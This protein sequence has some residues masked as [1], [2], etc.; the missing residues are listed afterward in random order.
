MTE[1]TGAA[2]LAPNRPSW[3]TVAC[4][5]AMA[6]PA[7]AGCDD[8]GEGD[9]PF[10]ARPADAGMG[11]MGE[12]DAGAV[13][14]SM[15]GATVDA[16]DPG[17]LQVERWG[18]RMWGT[19]SALSPTPEGMFVGTRSVEDGFDGEVHGQLLRVDR[20]TG[21]VRVWDDELPLAP[22]AFPLGPAGPTSTGN[23]VVAGGRTLAAAPT[24]VLV[25][26]GD[27]VTL[28]AIPG[29]DGVD[30]LT[31]IARSEGSLWASTG[32]G[33]FEL[34]LVTLTVRD[35][36]SAAELGGS[37]G[38]IATAPSGDLYAVVFGSSGASVVLIRDGAVARTL[39]PG[40]DG[41][42]AGTP[43]DIVFSAERGVAFVALGS[44]AATSGGVVTWDGESSEW[45]ASEGELSL[46][47]SSE[48]Q[49]FGASTLAIG[50]EDEVLLVGGQIQGGFAGFRG[51]GLALIDLSQLPALAVA[52][53]TAGASGLAGDHVTSLAWDDARNEAWVAAWQPCDESRLG[54]G[55]LDLLTWEGGKPAFRKPVLGGVRGL[56]VVDGEVWVGLRD[57]LPGNRCF[58]MNI[59]QGLAALR[60]DRTAEVVDIPRPGDAWWHPNRV[61][62]SMI[63]PSPAGDPLVL[64]TERDDLY[65]G[66]D[67]RAR[68]E[69][70]AFIGPSLFLQDAVWEDGDT[71]W[72]GGRATHQLGDGPELYDVG[73][74]GAARID[75]TSA[76]AIVSRTHYVR[77]T[78]DAPAPDEVTGLPSSD[79]RAIVPDGDVVWIVSATERIYAG[80]YDRNDGT[81]WTGE[82]G[83][84]RGGLARVERGDGSLTVVADAS[85]LPDGRAATLDAAGVLHVVDSQRGFLA[86]NGSTFDEVPLSVTVPEGA[87]P[88]TLWMGSDGELVIGYDLGAVVS[89]GGVTEWL[90]GFG[91]VWNA[92]ARGE[93][94]V[95]L[96]TDEGLVRVRAPGVAPIAE[97]APTP[98]QLPPFATVRGG[99]MTGGA[100]AGVSTDAGVD[101]SCKAEGERCFPDE[102]CP[103]LGCGGSGIVPAC[104][105]L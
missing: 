103:G 94:V 28:E 95:L 83:P 34:D 70:P 1:P 86:W 17:A 2:T 73:P 7:C 32:A 11:D 41:V 89:L 85:Q 52:G 79:V 57:D 15:D 6:L 59:Q 55:G 13:D 99:G 18:A 45:I 92:I 81:V 47:L 54:F 3:A 44:W 62:P 68:L 101:G 31:E 105:P 65:L 90:E 91:F 9:G 21:G 37:P 74:R 23:V 64:V 100:D 38:P 19:V 27:A 78:R 51:G 42:P 39:I 67:T 97:P 46:A 40:T 77:A 22:P 63:L 53:T 56:R 30:T 14:G 26:E 104:V 49:A 48:P 10:D 50:E 69:N 24:G 72:I 88:Q 61:G 25:I 33:L 5:L 29:V 8:G 4:I 35:M 84:R 20:T 16:G 82:S 76:G 36:L 80:D 12:G 75:V 98:G 102:C 87:I 60:S 66:D 58:G 71:L 43:R 93:G 96:G